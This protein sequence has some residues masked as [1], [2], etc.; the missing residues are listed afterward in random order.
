MLKWRGKKKNWHLLLS[1]SSYINACVWILCILHTDQRTRIQAE[2]GSV[3]G[4]T[5]SC[6]SLP[7]RSESLQVLQEIVLGRKGWFVSEIYKMKKIK[8]HTRRFRSLRLVF[9]PK[10]E[11]RQ[12]GDSA[13]FTKETRPF[14]KFNRFQGPPSR[15]HRS[16][17]FWSDDGVVL[18]QHGL[19]SLHCLRRRSQEG[20]RQTC[21]CIM[22]FSME[23]FAV[24]PSFVTS[25]RHQCVFFIKGRQGAKTM[26][27]NVVS[28]W[29][30]PDLFWAPP[31][32][33]FACSQWFAVSGNSMKLFFFFFFFFF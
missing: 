2:G 13:D 12:Q 15:K 4:H 20:Y 11:K 32:H 28:F 31:S 10:V 25:W 5:V 29:E 33:V 22:I 27:K 3:D 26:N 6:S 19:G 8:I 30:P 21:L 18:L 17:A 9:D 1:K 14:C 16:S 7:S 23:T 24:K